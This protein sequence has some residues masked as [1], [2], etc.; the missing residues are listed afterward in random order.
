MMY[1]STRHTVTGRTPTE[2]LRNR[3]IRTKLPTVKAI[4]TA[5]PEDPEACGRDLVSKFNGK[6]REDARRRA[7]PSEIQLGDTV[8]MKNLL[9]Q[10]KLETPFLNTR[11]VVKDKAWK[12]YDCFECG[13]HW[14]AL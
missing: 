1:N 14:E 7:R 10:N 3:T 5:P 9:P 6:E 11:F 8:L 12:Q 4:E 2:L 13:G